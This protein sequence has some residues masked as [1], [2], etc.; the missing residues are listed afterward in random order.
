[1][2]E[3]AVANE[4]L[5]LTLTESEKAVRDCARDLSACR[6]D[7]ERV[8][9]EKGVLTNR[10]KL[11]EA[12]VDELREELVALK[13]SC[14]TAEEAAGTDASRHALE[15][16]QLQREL[17]QTSTAARGRASVL[18]TERDAARSALESEKERRIKLE[19]LLEGRLGEVNVSRNVISNKVSGLE[20]TLSELT[21]RL[22][23]TT[24]ERDEAIDR[25]I[26]VW[27]IQ[28]GFLF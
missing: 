12:S 4:V 13:A 23:R 1:M 2:A 14:A 9:R 22:N 19:S 27:R 17:A 15:H 25:E 21:A 28:F 18:E 20:Q 24:C 16:S 3:G 8:T 5:R 26:K 6:S 7:Q 11:S 10:L